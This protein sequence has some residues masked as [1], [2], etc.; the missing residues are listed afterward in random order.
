MPTK[1]FT[2]IDLINYEV[3]PAFNKF[4]VNG[5]CD[6]TTVETSQAVVNVN[7]SGTGTGVAP[8]G[9]NITIAGATTIAG[10][11]DLDSFPPIPDGARITKIDVQI[12]AHANPV[13]SGAGSMGFQAGVGAN[14]TVSLLP[15]SFPLAD[16][17]L[18]GTDFDNGTGARSASINLNRTTSTHHEIFLPNMS[19]AAFQAYVGGGIEFSLGVNAG[20]GNTTNPAPDGSAALGG[21]VSLNNFIFTVTYEEGPLTGISIS[22]P[23]GP[24]QI[25]QILTVTSE[26]FDL[27][28]LDFFAEQDGRV[29]PIEPQIITE[30]EVWLEAPYPATDPCFDCLP[31]CPS[32]DN[33]F[34][35]C[36]DDLSDPKCVKA[37]EECLKCLSNCLENLEKAEECQQSTGNHPN[38]PS[39]IVIYA[40]SPG[41]QFTGNVQ[42]GEFEIIVAN[43]SGIYKFSSEQFH[44]TIYSTARDGTT[45]NVKI[46]NPGAKTGFFRS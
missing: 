32:C 8:D 27:E 43:G 17:G 10:D 34:T 14:I 28:E 41:H 45:Y 29:I 36:E 13:A 31:D 21:G 44:D 16:L 11:F 4:E 9:T 18:D 26:D 2:G 7:L 20:A 6:A 12:E 46:P 23:S 40:N 38:S 5:T 35:A 25:G 39:P 22:P 3:T 30:D 15:A 24:V 19:K 37:M 33:A 1:T 42:L